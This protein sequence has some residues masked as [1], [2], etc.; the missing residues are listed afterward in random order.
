MGS[1]PVHKLLW[2][3]SIPLIFS[4]LAHNLY[5]FVDSVFVSYV[6]EAALTALSIAALAEKYAE[7]A[8]CPESGTIFIS[9]SDCREDAEAL[10][11]LLAERH[12]VRV[13]LITSIGTVIG[14]HTGPGTIALF[15]VGKER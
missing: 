11:S 7:L 14:A 2:K 10:A 13:A 8:V 9:H 3:N 12:K 15:F 6:S 5:N 4:L 1:A